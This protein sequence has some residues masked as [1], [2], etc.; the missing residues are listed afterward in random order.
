MTP[1]RAAERISMAERCARRRSGRLNDPAPG[2]ADAFDVA[3]TG[4]ERGRPGSQRL[5]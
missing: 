3:G 1:T 4:R 5:R 2:I